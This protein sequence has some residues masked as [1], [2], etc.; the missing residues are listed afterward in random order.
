MNATSGPVYWAFAHGLGLRAEQNGTLPWL[1][2]WSV[3][4]TSFPY[5]LTCP[6]CTLHAQNEIISIENTTT[7]MVLSPF[8]KS[9]ELH[10]RVSVRLKKPKLS[11]EKAKAIWC[12]FADDNWLETV[13]VISTF[14]VRNW[15]PSHLPAYNVW[16]QKI[17]PTLV[18]MQPPLL[19]LPLPQFLPQSSTK[20]TT[21][22][23]N[24][25]V[26]TLTKEESRN[27]IWSDFYNEH[28]PDAPISIQAHPSYA[29][30]FATNPVLPAKRFY[31]LSFTIP[32]VLLAFI[33]FLWLIVR[34]VRL[35]THRRTTHK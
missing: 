26:V 18:S 34:L 12:R 14:I 3:F 30:L 8:A 16:F 13:W 11:L 24:S 10:N 28:H 4:F 33:L 31:W 7:T 15:T 17:F 6:T 9:V 5:L 21:Q 23:S 29:P 27:V 1:K 2:L 19:S 25:V 32:L 35:V 22:I 20:P